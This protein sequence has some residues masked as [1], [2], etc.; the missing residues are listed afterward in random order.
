MPVVSTAP[1]S[2]GHS[3]DIDETQVAQ[4]ATRV[5]GV[6]GYSGLNAS[7]GAGDGQVNL[8]PGYAQAYGH[9]AYFPTQ[10]VCTLPSVA[11]GTAWYLIYVRHDWTPTDAQGGGKATLEYGTAMSTAVVPST[12]SNTPGQVVDQAMFLAAR[13]AGKT[14]VQSIVD[15]RRQDSKLIVVQSDLALP[16]ATPGAVA[17]SRGSLR[18]ATPS[19]AGYVWKA[20]FPAPVSTR[21]MDP[22]SQGQIGDANAHRIMQLQIPDPGVP[23]RI[24][25]SGSFELSCSAR[26]D[27]KVE[28]KQ[29]SVGLETLGYTSTGAGSR[30]ASDPM[31]VPTDPSTVVAVGATTL[32]VWGTRNAPSGTWTVTQYNGRLNASIHPA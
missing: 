6:Y 15:V 18:V 30:S 14:A 27:I 32:E 31:R 26:V 9:E 1:Q 21:T 3:G 13:T 4:W 29:G 24:T 25:P 8:T 22:S 12:I 23:Y 28:W 11:N 20:A 5:G 10:Q 16:A 2:Y 7:I 19:G 17:L